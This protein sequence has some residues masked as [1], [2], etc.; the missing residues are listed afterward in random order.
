MN[1][2]LFCSTFALIFLAELPDKTAFATLL[3]ATRGHAR[4]VFTGV[5]TAF[6]IQTVV[7]I[8]F[9]G[10]IAQAPHFWVHL[11]TGVL[12]VGFAAQMW[13]TR[14]DES[15]SGSEVATELA[16]SSDP[17]FWRVAR[18]AFVV[19]FIAEWGD[20]TQIATASLAA[21][22]SHDKVTIFISALL[23]L[24]AVTA[25]AVGIGKN[26]EKWISP[27]KVQRISAGLFLIIGIYFLFDAYA[28][29]T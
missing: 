25:V 16:G 15:D 2:S 6:F 7:A 28:P 24:W 29:T 9:G 22:Y 23:A 14:N 11:A 18:N 10:L 3:L 13:R 8:A 21:K 1:F 26:A 20:L 4:A 5:A 27:K 12:F 17:A 19:I